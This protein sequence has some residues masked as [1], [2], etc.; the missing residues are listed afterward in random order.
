MKGY[1][2]SITLEEN[3]T[4][5]EEAYRI[6]LALVDSVATRMRADGAK[7]Y[8]VVVTIRDRNFKDRSHQMKLAEAT[9]VTNEIYGISKKLLSELWDGYTPLQLLGVSLSNVTHEDTTQ[10]SLFEDEK[11]D[12]SGKLDKALDAIRGKYGAIPSCGPPRS[13]PGG[14]WAANTKRRSI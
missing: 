6:V 2:N 7:A 1:G 14:M 9:D 10:F 8:C 3:V 5:T 11:K 13:M 12:R 4:T